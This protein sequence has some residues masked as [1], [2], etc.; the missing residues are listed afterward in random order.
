MNY[1]I[2]FCL[3]LH[4]SLIILTTLEEE[5]YRD[6]NLERFYV[7]TQIFVAETKITNFFWLNILYRFRYIFNPNRDDRKYGEA[8]KLY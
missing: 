7:I 8:C 3:I 5:K 4:F 1:L 2:L 6:L